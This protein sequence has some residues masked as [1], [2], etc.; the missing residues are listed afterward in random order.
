[1]TQLLYAT[2]NKYKI[3]IA[4]NVLEDFD[5]E[6][7]KMPDQEFEVTEIQSDNQEEVAIHKAENYFT[8]LNKP[9]VSMDSGLFINGLKGFPG[10]YTKYALD[11]I[12][13]D[14]IMQLMKNTEN[15]SAYT[16]RT[17]AFT[18]GNTTMTFV[19]RCHGILLSAKRGDEGRDYDAIFLVDNFS[20]TLSEMNDE[21]KGIV[22]GE[23]WRRLGEWLQ[24]DYIPHKD[25]TYGA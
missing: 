23:P 20:K 7:V 21:E 4:N 25:S 18:D 8:V 2:T 14:G 5:I 9:L 24:K 3:M 13:V 6:L 15:K 19:S 10:V 22:M 12:G 17:V 1:M 16:Q 11:T